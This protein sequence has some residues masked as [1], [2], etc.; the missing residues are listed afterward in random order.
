MKESAKVWTVSCHCQV[1]MFLDN[2]YK[3]VRNY[4]L[5]LVQT[6]TCKLQHPL[7][8][9][10]HLNVADSGDGS[11]GVPFEGV[12]ICCFNLVSKLLVCMRIQVN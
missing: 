11:D 7:W 2:I 8:L 3:K 10:S 5:I 1:Q 12:E 6:T 9:V 4:F